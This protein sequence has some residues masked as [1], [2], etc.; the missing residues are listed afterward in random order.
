MNNTNCDYINGKCCSGC[1]PGYIGKLCND[2]KKYKS[3]IYSVLDYS[4]VTKYVS[5]FLLILKPAKTVIMDKTVLEFAP[6]SARHV[7]PLTEHVVALLVGW[8]LTVVLVFVKLV[9][10]I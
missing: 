5:Y 2:C 9:K 7:N 10:I 6:Q 3:F 1:Q 4:F 8:D